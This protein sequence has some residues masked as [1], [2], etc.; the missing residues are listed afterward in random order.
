YDTEVF[1][2]KWYVIASTQPGGAVH[3]Y[4]N[5]ALVADAPF[6]LT[7]MSHRSKMY[8]IWG[9]IV[10]FSALNNPGAWTPNATNVGAGFIQLDGQDEGSV[11]LVAM[12]VYY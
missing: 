10:Y 5:G 7:C 4:Y 1:D 6:G 9:N 2:G 8:T 3:H 11:S 12:S